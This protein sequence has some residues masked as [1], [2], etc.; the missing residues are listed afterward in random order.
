MPRR[1]AVA[2]L[3]LGIVVVIAELCQDPDDRTAEEE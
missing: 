3:L 1:R 2:A